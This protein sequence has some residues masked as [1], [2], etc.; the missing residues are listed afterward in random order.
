MDFPYESQ[1]VD[2]LGSKMH[3]VDTGGEGMDKHKRDENSQYQR[4]M[5]LHDG[6]LLL[7]V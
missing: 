7:V 1:Y 6:Y 3:S 5:L 4:Y 2:V